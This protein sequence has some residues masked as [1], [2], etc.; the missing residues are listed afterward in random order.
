MKTIYKIFV[1]LTKI[2]FIK[3]FH[4]SG[5]VIKS[6]KTLTSRCRWTTEFAIIGKSKLSIGMIES[7]AY[8]RL[9]AVSGGNLKIGDHCFFNRNCTIISRNSIE[10]GEGCTLGPNVCIYDH[11]H[12]FGRNGQTGQFKLGKIIIGDNCW[13]GADAII[14]RDTVIGKN[15]VIA[16][17]CVVK[18]NI[19]DSSIVSMQRE[20]II[21][22]LHD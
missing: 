6:A 12:V 7:A 18:G 19:P 15:C 2:I 4:Y 5:L 20:L 9:A 1:F 17:G 16:A 14:L 8:T 10:I 21:K 3:L 22:P 13:I 11:D